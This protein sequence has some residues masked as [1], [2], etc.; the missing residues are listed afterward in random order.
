M[1]LSRDLTSILVEVFPWLKKYVDPMTGKLLV[2]I[3]KAL[4]GL[5]QSA[6]L[7]FEALTAFVKSLGFVPNTIDNC[8]MNKRSDGRNVTIVL[9]VDDILILSEKRDDIDWLIDALR[10]EYGELSIESGESFTYLG[11]G[12]ETNQQG[13]IQL[14]MDAYIQGV[15]DE[16]EHDYKPLKKSTTPASIRL[17][18]PGT[19]KLLQKRDRSKFHTT[20]AKLLYLSK[21]ARPDIQLPVLYLCTRVKNP[22][23]D[24]FSKL[25]KLL[26]YL[27]LTKHK[28]RLISR[29]GDMNRLVAY[30]DAS[31]AS[32]ADGKGHTGLVLKWGIT[33]LMTISRKQKIATKDSTEAELVGLS[34]TLV[35]VEK[36][37]EYMKEQ[38]IELDTPVIYQDNMSTMALVESET[39]GNVRTRHLSARRAIVYEAAQ[40]RKS[41]SIRFLRTVEM[42]ADVLTKPLSGRLFYKFSDAL[43]GKSNGESDRRG[44]VHAGATGVRCEK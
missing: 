37:N 6:A 25:L 17:F 10:R 4:Y 39:S 12:L 16:F 22:T 1:E 14:R 11:M 40:V 13:E 38:G 43:M 36:A 21:R 9:Y 20:V 41:V 28:T 2:Q 32:H 29:R 23:E 19:G 18:N 24:D 15:L 44:N 27:K 8:V 3:L 33:T 42:V 7:W 5:V 35:E 30:V 26:G 31:F 34:D